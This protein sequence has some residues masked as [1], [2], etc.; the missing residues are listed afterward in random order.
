MFDFTGK[1]LALT[2]ANG[3]ISQ[4]IA[5][6]EQVRA[7]G[8]PQFQVTQQV[9]TRFAEAIEQAKVDVVPRIVIGGNGGEAGEAGQSNLMQGLLAMLLSERMGVAGGTEQRQR[10]EV[11]EMRAEIY[12]KLRAPVEPITAEDVTSNRAM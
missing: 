11:E 12:R 7:Y 1:V 2:G 6:E 5:I 8:G 4:A 9:M 3:G 10:P